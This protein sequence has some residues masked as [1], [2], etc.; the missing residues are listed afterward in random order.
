MKIKIYTQGGCINC[1][2]VKGILLRALP[3]FG[4][5]YASSVSEI[6]IDDSEVLAEL[7]M[8]GAESV[9]VVVLGSSSLFGPPVLDEER[10]RNL[11]VVNLYALKQQTE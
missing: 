8:M 11:I 3:E 1:T 9:P 6:G 2:R 5:E 10:L 4:L 7:I